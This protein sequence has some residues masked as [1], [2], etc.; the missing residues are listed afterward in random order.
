MRSPNDFR[1]TTVGVWAI[2]AVVMG[3]RL[4]E[5]LVHGYKVVLNRWCLQHLV[6]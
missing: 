2:H 3:T 1:D 5:R 4:R 6:P